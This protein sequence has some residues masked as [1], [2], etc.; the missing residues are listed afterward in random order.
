MARDS[1]SGLKSARRLAMLAGMSTS[2]ESSPLEAAEPSAYR[3]P[4]APELEATAPDG[5]DASPADDDPHAALSPAVR[6]LV[7][8]F[9]L[10]I[11]GIHGTGPAG[12]IRVGDV[13]ALLEGR[14]DSGNRAAAFAGTFTPASGDAPPPESGAEID[15]A[16]EEPQAT[17]IRPPASVALAIPTSTVFECDLSRV[18][19]HR[20]R[21]RLEHVDVL[22]TSYFVAAFSDALGVVPEVARGATGIG[23]E[24]TTTD[25]ATRTALV[26]SATIASGSFEERVRAFDTALKLGLDADVAAA[27]LLIH[28]YGATGSLLATPTPLASGRAA[29]VGIGRVRREIVLRKVDGVEQPRVA[30]RCYVSLSFLTDRIAFDRAN[31]FV[32]HAVRVLEQTTD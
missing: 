20:K 2:D 10:D 11:S 18:L 15:A 3:E 17:P 26:D 25:G 8:Q 4:D 13:M 21:L 12:R 27:G 31:R 30:A 29:S 23:V 28:Y 32:A 16:A 5:S 6:R 1:T 22:L 7:R 9:D 24:L 19:A 14:T